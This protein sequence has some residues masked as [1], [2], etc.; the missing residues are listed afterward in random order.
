MREPYGPKAFAAR[1][2][3]SRETFAR[4][5]AYAD[6]LSDWNRRHNLVSR[7]SMP[8]LWRRHFLDSAQLAP[9]VPEAARTL[10]DLGSGAGFPGLVLAAMLGDR[11]K[12]TLFEATTKKCAFLSAAAARMELN[13]VRVL[14]ARM[15]DAPPQAFDVI[16]SRA[17]A[18][19]SRLLGY[20]VRFT[21]AG[22]VCLFLK[23]QN[24]G[25][26]LTEAHKYWSMSTAQLPSLSDPSGAILEVRELEAHDRTPQKA[27]RPGRRQSERRRR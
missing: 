26:E 27:P 8:D 17:C 2:D 15:E 22:T 11:L 25:Q 1:P 12:V 7:S 10:V 13:N 6:L 4:L 23:G 3:V 14:N 9:L 21:G 5:K 19:L 20:A 16:T 18:P 24:L